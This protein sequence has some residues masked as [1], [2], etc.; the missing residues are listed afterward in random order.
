MPRHELIPIDR[1]G[2]LLG[3]GAVLAQAALR[4]ARAA[5]AIE[6]RVVANAGVENRTLLELME[7]QG[8]LRSHG[9]PCRP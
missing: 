8:V 9:A 5:D 7:R 1:R 4:C 6:L 3:S 2:L